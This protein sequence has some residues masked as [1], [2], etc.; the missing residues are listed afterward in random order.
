[1]LRPGPYLVAL[2]ALA[3]VAG[4]EGCHQS[5]RPFV[6]GVVCLKD[7]QD[8]S[9]LTNELRTIATSESTKLGDRGAETQKELETLGHPDKERTKPAVNLSI[10]LGDGIGLG[11]S[12][13]AM[14]GYQVAFGV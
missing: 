1:M 2:L 13:L 10:E 6:I 5:K 4:L 9:D 7:A 11:V 12:N 14:P 3:M 8:L